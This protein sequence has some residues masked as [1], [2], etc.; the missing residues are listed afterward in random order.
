VLA[1][2]CWFG[3]MCPKCP[4][5][6]SAPHYKFMRKEIHKFLFAWES[7]RRKSH[8]GAQGQEGHINNS[9]EKKECLF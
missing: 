8:L 7:M 2:C 3:D 1:I 5:C 6:P 4:Y 9:D